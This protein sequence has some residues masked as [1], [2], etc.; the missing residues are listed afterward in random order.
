MRLA[1]RNNKVASSSGGR[2]DIN[3]LTESVKDT[4]AERGWEGYAARVG[5]YLVWDIRRLNRAVDRIADLVS[6]SNRQ[7]LE[8]IMVL[9]ATPDGRKRFR[10]SGAGRKQVR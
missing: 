9:C 6:S 8:E 3:I 1:E 10:I 7:R 4:L 5:R 2:H